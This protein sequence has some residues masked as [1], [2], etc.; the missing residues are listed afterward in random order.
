MNYIG[1][2]VHK[3]DSYIAVL[4]DD[5]AVVEEVRVENAN[6]DDFAQAY[7]KAKAVIEATG[8]YYTIYDTLDQYMDVVVADPGQTKAIGYAE[9]KNDRLDKVA[10][11]TSSSQHDRHQLRP[12]GRDP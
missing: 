7:P 9:V 3:R 12:I 6:L 4:N 1:I 11:S 2:D 5:G 10:R 8:N